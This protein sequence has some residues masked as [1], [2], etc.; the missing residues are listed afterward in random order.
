MNEYI[1]ELFAYTFIAEP[2]REYGEVERT[3]ALDRPGF[4]S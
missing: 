2:V 4:A 1:S 3:W